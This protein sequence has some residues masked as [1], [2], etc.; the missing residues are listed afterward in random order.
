[1]NESDNVIEGELSVDESD[2]FYIGGELK[3][4]VSFMPFEKYSFSFNVI[5]LQIG[6]LALPKFNI[7]EVIEPDRLTMLIKGFTKKCLVVK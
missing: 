6:R 1:M 4:F 3:S 7:Q 5:P 2:E